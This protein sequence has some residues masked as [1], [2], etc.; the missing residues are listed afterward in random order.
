RI[1][2]LDG[3]IQFFDLVAELRVPPALQ[4]FEG[5][6]ERIEAISYGLRVRTRVGLTAGEAVGRFPRTLDLGL[7]RGQALSG[8]RRFHSAGEH[9]KA[10]TRVLMVESH[11]LR[12][13]AGT[14]FL[15]LL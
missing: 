4:A 11:R 5:T 13:R 6:G 15:V 14:A 1:H 3:L 7:Y 2:S 10:F 9:P 8:Q 12:L